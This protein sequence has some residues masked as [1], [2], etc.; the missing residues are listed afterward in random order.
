FLRTFKRSGIGIVVFGLGNGVVGEP[1][2][3]VFEDVELDLGGGR[4]GLEKG[5]ADIGEKARISGVVFVSEALRRAK[6]KFLG[7]QKIIVSRKWGFTK[8]SRSDYLK[9][10][11][12]NMIVPDGVNAKLLG[13]H[14]PLANRQPGRAFLT[15]ATA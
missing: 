2:E 12:E 8:F 3:E 9:Y 10:K 5:V 4:G 11:S 13:C 14:G 15:S 7:R 6:F 1:E